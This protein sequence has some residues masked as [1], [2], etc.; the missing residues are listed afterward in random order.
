MLLAIGTWYGQRESI[1][2]GTVAHVAPHAAEMLLDMDRIV[3]V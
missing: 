1:T 2:V 3:P